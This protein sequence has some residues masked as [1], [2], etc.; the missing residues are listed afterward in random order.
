M[1]D[2]SHHLVTSHIDEMMCANIAEM[3]IRE[4][5]SFDSNLIMGRFAFLRSCKTILLH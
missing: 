5:Y 1:E 4:A 2:T 3:A